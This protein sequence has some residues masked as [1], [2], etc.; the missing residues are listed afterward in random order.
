M[1]Q[2]LDVAIFGPLKKHLIS[3]LSHL[4]EAQLLRIQKAEWLEAYIHAHEV[5]F[6]NLNITSAWRGSGLQPFQPQTVIRAATLQPPTP[7]TPQRPRTP[8]EHDIFEKVFINSSPPDFNPL[9]KANSVLSTAL[10]QGVLNMP[11]K[12]YIHKL[13]DETEKLNTCH[14]LQQRETDNLRNIIQKRRAQ[15]KGKRAVLKG[16]FYISTQ[17]LQSQGAEAEA[18][19]AVSQKSKISTTPQVTTSIINLTANI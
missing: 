16:Q 7:A 15:N 1:L 3:A 13:A 4:N 10:N 2:P 14:I 11:T 17:E 5:T 9:Q 6:S 18:A 19:T 12:R 8:T